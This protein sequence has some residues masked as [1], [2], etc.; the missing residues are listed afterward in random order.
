MMLNWGVA[1]SVRHF[2]SDTYVEELD[3]PLL[4]VHRPCPLIGH[5]NIRAHWKIKRY[6]GNGSLIAEREFT[7]DFIQRKNLSPPRR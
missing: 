5:F 7:K 1:L 2:D 4:I 6:R 3:L